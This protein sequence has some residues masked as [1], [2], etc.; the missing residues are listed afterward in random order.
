MQ[1]NRSRLDY[2]SFSPEKTNICCCYA[3][4]LSKLQFS[5]HKKRI[6][7][8][9]YFN[10]QQTYRILRSHTGGYEEFHPLRYTGR[11]VRWKSTNVSEK[12]VAS[13]CLLP[14]TSWFLAWPILRPWK[15]KRHVPPKRRLFFNGLHGVISQKK[16]VFEKINFQNT[17]RNT[18]LKEWIIYGLTSFSYNTEYN[19]GRVV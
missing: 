1:K 14:T 10:V 6:T 19:L 3:E 18:F 17:K 9:I 2:I 16:E 4:R 15:W 12:H 5:N 8:Y 11:V 7:H 13:S